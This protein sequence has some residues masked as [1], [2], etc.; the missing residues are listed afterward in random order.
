[1]VGTRSKLQSPDE[2]ME[3]E[4]EGRSSLKTLTGAK[5]H[6]METKEPLPHSQ[7]SE[8]E[9]TIKTQLAQSV[10]KLTN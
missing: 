4:A 9:R 6:K 1:M 7:F 5:R 2:Q 8:G 10:F 3:G